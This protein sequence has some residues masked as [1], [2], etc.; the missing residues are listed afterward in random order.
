MQSRRDSAL[1]L[2]TDGA[3]HMYIEA[4][5]FFFRE[6]RGVHLA[7]VTTHGEWRGGRTPPIGMG[8]QGTKAL[9]DALHLFEKDIPQKRKRKKQEKKS[10]KNLQ[11]TQIAWKILTVQHLYICKF[12]KGTWSYKNE[13]KK[14]RSSVKLRNLHPMCLR[15]LSYRCAHTHEHTPFHNISPSACIIAARHAVRSLS[16]THTHP[17]ATWVT[18]V[19]VRKALPGNPKCP[20]QHPISSSGFVTFS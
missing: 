15:A 6:P 7:Q 20:E 2:T 12:T 10:G 8:E 5:F 4:F 16:C 9:R 17:R 1:V 11:H 19:N 18:S 14:K 3:S 13:K